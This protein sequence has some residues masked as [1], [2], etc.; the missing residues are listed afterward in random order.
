MLT[1]SDREKFDSIMENVME[2][3]LLRTSV[4]E[5]D[6]E[7]IAEILRRAEQSAA[8]E[9]AR[10]I[11]SIN[12]IGGYIGNTSRQ[13]DVRQSEEKTDFSSM[14]RLKKRFSKQSEES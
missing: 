3:R 8:E 10:L 14:A 11:E 9:H 12:Q 7:K 5:R 1:N 4:P 2:K 13:E 6:E